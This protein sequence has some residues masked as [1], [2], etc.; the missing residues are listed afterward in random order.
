[1]ATANGETIMKYLVPV[2]GAIVVALQGVNL[3][4]TGN[5]AH[6]AARVEVEQKQELEA[7]R[8]LQ[9]RLKIVL[10]QMSE[11]AKLAPPVYEALRRIETKLGITDPSLPPL[12]SPSPTPQ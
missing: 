2:I 5:V 8:D 12:P 6:E 10:A 7:I 3:G 9:G 11:N 1:M 4:T